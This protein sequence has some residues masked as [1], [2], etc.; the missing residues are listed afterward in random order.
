MAR[1]SSASFTWEN[2]LRY[3]WTGREY[4]AETGLYY[5]RARYYSPTQRRF[6]AE[7]P[8]ASGLSPYAYVGGSP[9]EATDPSGMMMSYAMRMTDPRWDALNVAGGPG[10]VIDGV[11]YEGGLWL[12]GF[13][14]AGGVSI[15][16]LGTFSIGD[17]VTNLE[18]NTTGNMVFEDDLARQAFINLRNKAFDAGDWDLIGLTS[19]AA[20]ANIAVLN[21]VPGTDPTGTHPNWS[22]DCNYACYF[23]NAVWFG[24][25]ISQAGPE[26]Y[27]EGYGL[28]RPE[29]LLAHEL[30][31]AIVTLPHRTHNG[32]LN[33][34]GERFNGL[35]YD[36]HARQAFGCQPRPQYNEMPSC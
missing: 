29:V 16:Q 18:R 26:L 2:Q 5:L 9:L 30:G 7:D 13:A 33:A 23:N 36:Q 4:D 24:G 10:K 22:E 20:H 31:H 21:Y 11:S 27:K 28:V 6:L 19:F 25:N 1:D 15:T 34:E 17:M 3:G 12:E 32:F 14:F 35:Y 8:V